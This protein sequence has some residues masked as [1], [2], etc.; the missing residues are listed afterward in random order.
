MTQTARSFCQEWGESLHE[1]ICDWDLPTLDILVQG[2]SGRTQLPEMIK[3]IILCDFRLMA[4]C[5]VLNYISQ[6]VHQY[7]FDGMPDLIS[8]RFHDRFARTGYGTRKGKVLKRYKRHLLGRHRRFL[9]HKDSQKMMSST[10]DVLFDKGAQSQ[11]GT[12]LKNHVEYHA[13]RVCD[14]L[15]RYNIDDKLYP[16]LCIFVPNTY[17]H[18]IGVQMTIHTKLLQRAIDTAM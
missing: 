13:G 11:L 14:D 1:S 16:R 5:L 6:P 18:G 9:D 15:I 2:I 8:Q 4:H 3:E 10:F 12:N 7:P 17:V